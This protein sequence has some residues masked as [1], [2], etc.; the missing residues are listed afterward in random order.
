[1]RHEQFGWQSTREKAWSKHYESKYE[2]NLSAAERQSLLRIV[3]MQGVS[4]RRDSQNGITVET[5]S[6]VFD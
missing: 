3:L 2:K 5:A 6:H 1:M 4:P